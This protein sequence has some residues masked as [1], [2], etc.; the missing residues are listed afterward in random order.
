MALALEEAR[1]RILDLNAPELPF[2]YEPTPEGVIAHWKYADVQWTNIIA[3]G[4]ADGSYE[5][6]VV[7]DPQSSTWKF[8]ESSSEAS[9]SVGLGGLST[10]RSWHHGPQKRFSM[11]LGGAIAALTTDRRGTSD[12]HAYGWKFS[13]DEVKAPVVEALTAAGWKSGNGFF[14]RLFGG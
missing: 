1:R 5:L 12:G 13:S 9:H 14:S 6:R 3:G 7:L 10:T 4:A 8:H 2:V 11:S